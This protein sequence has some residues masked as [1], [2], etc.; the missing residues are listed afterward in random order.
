MANELGDEEPMHA[1]ITLELDFT[2]QCSDNVLDAALVAAARLAAIAI[3]NAT[4]ERAGG[5]DV[6]GTRVRFRVRP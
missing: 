6:W 1:T 5:V 3:S 4:P 2:S